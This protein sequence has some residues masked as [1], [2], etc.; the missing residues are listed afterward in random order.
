MSD[1]CILIPDEIWEMKLPAKEAITFVFYLGSHQ[2]F[3][4]DQKRHISDYVK[5]RCTVKLKE[6]GM[7]DD[8][9]IPTNPKNWKRPQKVSE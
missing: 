6:L 5:K 8:S 9:C 4:L 1:N 7:I 2:G 3:N